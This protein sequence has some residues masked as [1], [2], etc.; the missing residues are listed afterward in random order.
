MSSIFYKENLGNTSSSDGL[1]DFLLSG[2]LTYH[3]SLG[4]FKNKYIPYYIQHN[5]LNEWEIGLG[6]VIDNLGQDVLVRSSNI[7]YPETIVYA[8]SNN[9]QAVSFSAGS[10]TVRSVIS[11]ERINHGGNNFVA[12]S[13]NFIADTIQ[14]TY[15]ILSSGSTVTA[16]L[17][18]ASGNDNLV[19]SFRIL[20]GSTDNVIITASGSQNIDG[21]SSVILKPIQKYTSLISDGSSWYQLNRDIEVDAA[22]LPIGNNGNIQFKVSSTEFGGSN[23]LHWDDNDKNLLLGSDSPTS[24]NVII[25]ATSGQ[26]IIF[27]KQS[28]DSNFQVKGTGTNQL[29]FDASTGRLGLNTSSPS[30]IL[31]II[32]R[33]ANDTMRLESSTSC[34]TGVSL[35]LYHN[36]SNGSQIGDNPATINLAG[37][38]S[39]GQQINY[40]QIKSRI[41]G[42]NI[43]STSGELIFSVDVSGVSTNIL[44]T[45]PR[46][47]IIGLGSQSNDLDNVIIGSLSNNSGI[48]NIVIG[49]NSYVSG[50]TSSNNILFGNSTNYSGSGSILGSHNSNVFGSRAFVLGSSNTVNSNDIIILGSSTTSSGN[51]IVVNGRNNTLTGSYITVAGGDNTITSSLSGAIYGFNNTTNN[52]SGI[53]IGLSNNISGI[54]NIVFSNSSYINGIDNRIM[55]SDILVS[56]SSNTV[57]G[58]SNNITGTGNTVIAQSLTSTS[59]NSI[60]IGSG[61]T[62]SINNAVVIGMSAPDIVVSSVGVIINSGLRTSDINIYGGSSNSGLFYRNNKLGVNIVPNNY[63]LDVSGSM[64]GDSIVVNALRVGLSTTSGSVL[65]SDT[66]GNASWQSASSLQQNITQGLLSNTLVSY[67]GSSLVS[68][69]GLYWSSTSGLLFTSNS[70]TIIPTG[71]STFIINNNNNPTSNIFNIK[72]SGQNSLFVVNAATNTIGINT[73]NPIYNLDSSGTVRFYTNSLYFVERNNNQFTIAYDIGPSSPNRLS[74]TS[75][76]VIIDQTI[77]GTIFPTHSYNTTYPTKSS[78]DV[79]KIVVWDN[80]DNKLKYTTTITAGFEAFNGSSDS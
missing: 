20:N 7:S 48:S 42:T 39:N 69:T 55:G 50:I 22:G 33:C 78:A 79:A 49:N 73:S 9:N 11:S 37:R 2:S 44:T 16:Q 51:F 3:N 70:N 34:A 47:T 54:K 43:N 45:H 23:Q 17:P 75:S 6:I 10:K 8:S 61:L 76:G 72:G 64:R 80:S 29:F 67:D 24:A 27:N 57:F 59:N 32:G 26:N 19:L 46:K 53:I 4:S 62:S 18:S 66:L 71:N 63:V 28:Y 25:P 1:N 14:T 12:R 38:N 58:P 65:V 15:G 40:A 68:T 52:S 30:T 41:L 5:T 74:I 31:H 13:S 36:P 21:A 56:G 77:A 60:I 35:T